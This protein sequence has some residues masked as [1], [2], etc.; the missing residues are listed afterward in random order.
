[1]SMHSPALATPRPSKNVRKQYGR[2]VREVVGSLRRD[3]DGKWRGVQ[4]MVQ[5][6]HGSPK[7]WQSEGVGTGVGRGTEGVSGSSKGV[8][9]ISVREDEQGLN[10]HNRRGKV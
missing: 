4:W 10:Q 3:R 7:T 2:I 6:C 8:D 9:T 1:M 5:G